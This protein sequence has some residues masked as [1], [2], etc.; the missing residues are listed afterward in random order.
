MN[1]QI[2][3]QRSTKMV[4]TKM[5][6]K[7]GHKSSPIFAEIAARYHIEELR[8][9]K[10]SIG[11][12]EVNPLTQDL[13]HAVTCLSAELYTKHVHFLMELIQVFFFYSNMFKDSY[14]TLTCMFFFP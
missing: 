13:H 9:K 3:S 4:K 2:L 8:K 5:K 10:F 7:T 6:D 12:K 11:S 1:Q 14:F